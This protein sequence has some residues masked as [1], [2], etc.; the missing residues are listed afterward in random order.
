VQKSR[1]RVLFKVYLELQVI[2]LHFAV[3]AGANVVTPLAALSN[4]QQ[5]VVAEL[6]AAQKEALRAAAVA[7]QLPCLKEPKMVK[8]LC[9]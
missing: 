9:C 8:C 4:L 2:S 5:L 6:S 1:Q 3:P 7:G